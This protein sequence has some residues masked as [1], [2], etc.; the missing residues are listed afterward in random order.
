M[1]MTKMLFRY[2]E[3]LLPKK[4]TALKKKKIKLLFNLVDFIFNTKHIQ[5]VY[6]YE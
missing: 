5:Q 6:D 1:P 2:K 4:K 3:E